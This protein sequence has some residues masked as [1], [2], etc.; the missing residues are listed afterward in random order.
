MEK[1]SFLL[2]HKPTLTYKDTPVECTQFYFKHKDT[3]MEYTTAELDD[4]NIKLVKIAHKCLK[5]K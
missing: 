5:Q 2:E 3:K 4:I 1:E